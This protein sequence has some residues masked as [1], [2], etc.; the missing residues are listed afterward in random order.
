MPDIRQLSRSD[1][2]LIFKSDQAVRLVEDLIRAINESIPADVTVV[3]GNLDAHIAD[4]SDAHAASAIGNTPAGGVSSTTVQGA[5][6]ELDTEKQPQDA[7][8][9]AFA[10]LAIAASKI[11][12]GTG[13]DAFGLLDLDTDGALA[14]NSDTR[15]PTQKAV[16]SYAD[17]LIAASDAMVFKGVIDCSANPNYPAADR[18]HTY[19]VSVAGKIGGA[20]GV[21]VEVGDILLCMVDGSAA[22]NQAT[23]GANW[24]VI[25]ANIDGAVV[26][27]AS[28][29]SGN[30]ATF[31][32]TS[33]R[34][35]QD[36]GKALPTGAIVGTTDAQTLT[37]KTLTAPI[38]GTISNTGTLTLPTTTDT[39]VGRDTTDTLTH[40][41]LTQPVVN[42][43]TGAM[44]LASGSL[45]YAAGNGGTVT[46]ATSKSTGVTLNKISGEITTDAAALAAGVSA[47]FTLTNS[48]IAATD[49]I[50]LNHL[51]GG[52]FMAYDLD[53]QA[54]AGSATIGL[55]NRTGGA[56]SEAIVIGFT[57]IKSANA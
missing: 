31:N 48:T 36:G 19:R 13:V 52:T 26:G 57:V 2:Y 30:I 32:G 20:S 5:I 50:I 25:Q 34:T 44:T 8:L 21:S 51:S 10:A 33:G 45:G 4:T 29:V 22:G 55:R 54:G 38:F 17:S 3:Q 9:T 47:S 18:G 23:V 6:N 15:I 39:L 41:T 12:Y 14:A 56:L 28:S 16:K 46:Q 27:P 37:N 43:P 11:P 1:L 42:N 49:R 40:K 35:I 53:A 24:A 7:T